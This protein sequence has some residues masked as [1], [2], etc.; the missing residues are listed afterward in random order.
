MKA[1]RQIMTLMMLTILH[2][3]VY[4]QSSSLDSKSEGILLGVAPIEQQN[5]PNTVCVYL[6]NKLQQ[7]ATD[8][9]LGV[10][11]G[12]TRFVITAS[13]I[14]T[15]K[16]VVAGPPIQFAQNMDITFYIVDNMDKKVFSSVTMSAKAVEASEEK[17][18][19][20]A[21]RTIN[22]TSSP[23]TSFVNRGKEKIIAYYESQYPNIIAKAKSLAKQKLYG[24]ALFELCMIPE[25]CTEAYSKAT[26]VAGDIYDKYVDYEGN[27]LLA[28]AK[29]VWMAEQSVVG[30]QKAG[31]YLSLISIDASCYSQ[32]EN[33]YKEIKT[34][35]AEDLDFE[36]QVYKDV[37]N[38]EKQKVNAWKEVGIA[39][40]KGQQ[41]QTTNITWLH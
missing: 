14:P 7:V 40:G 3:S 18:L 17:A 29:T 9:G 41:Q 5:I 10:L 37:T 13:I 38:I 8:N 26:I 20:K 4:G 34:V 33:L 16:D 22:V 30:A 2:F 28:K 23:I 32:V 19:I 25:C 24:A 36:I 1:M 27:Q 39:Y 31:E 15:T 11:D 12:N 21:I 35:V 6:K